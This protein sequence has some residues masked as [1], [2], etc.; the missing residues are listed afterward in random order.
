MLA[1]EHG[2]RIGVVVNDFGALD[3]DAQ[4]IVGVESGTASVANGCVCCEV[5][6]DLVAAIAELPRSV[7]RVKG[8]V[9]SA[10]DSTHRFVLQAV[11][12]RAEVHREEPWGDRIPSTRPVVVADGATVDRATVGR[13]IAE[14]AVGRAAV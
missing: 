1:E 9:H 11:G 6:G 7:Y 2:R 12:R 14:S 8:F 13:T 4:L 3:V 10:T 5:R